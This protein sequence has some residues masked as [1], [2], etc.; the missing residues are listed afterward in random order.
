[1]LVYLAFFAKNLLFARK[2]ERYFE[3]G[4]L[5]VGALEV[6]DFFSNTQIF[7]KKNARCLHIC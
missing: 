7:C 2:C 6:T 3:V 1:M 4:R 5:R